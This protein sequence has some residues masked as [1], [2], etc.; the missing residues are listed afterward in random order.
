MMIW[1]GIW[2]GVPLQGLWDCLFHGPCAGLL[3]SA[4][5]C[6]PPLRSSSRSGLRGR[7]VRVSYSIVIV[8]AKFI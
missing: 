5:D 4:M 7:A 6:S 3:P 8:F 1:R 2:V